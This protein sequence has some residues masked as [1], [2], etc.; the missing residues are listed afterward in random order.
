MCCGLHR[1]KET[2]K[3]LR[4]ALLLQLCIGISIMGCSTP[5]HISRQ[6]T[7]VQQMNADMFECRQLSMKPSYGMVG[8]AMAGS[9]DPDP[10][11]YMLCL[12]AKGYTIT[13]D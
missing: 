1:E 3:N 6:G 10:E 5:Y 12:Q 9:V 2:M 8:G 4:S 13:Y 7:S 11:S